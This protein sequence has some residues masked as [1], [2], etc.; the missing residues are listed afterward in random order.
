GTVVQSGRVA[1]GDAAARLERRFEPGQRLERRIL[2]GALVLLDQLDGHDLRLEA[3]RRH[4]GHGLLMAGER[5][6]VLVRA[7]YGGLLGGVLGE[8]AHVHVRER[9][10]QAVADHPVHELAVPYLDPAAHAVHV[11]R[12]VGHR[13]HA[14]GHHALRVRCFNRLRGEHDGLE[15]GAHTLLMVIAGTV[16]GRPAWIA[17]WRAG[18]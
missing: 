15:P 10:P 3:T 13:L 9:I 18:A 2:A 6:T 17:A 7:R 5:E 8:A 4:G 14:T 11:V 1:R 16:P 12:R